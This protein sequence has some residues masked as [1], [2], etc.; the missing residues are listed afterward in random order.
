MKVRRNVAH[1]GVFGYEGGRR[2]EIVGKAL[3]GGA[4]A[5]AGCG[6]GGRADTRGWFLIDRGID[7]VRSIVSEQVFATQPVE[8]DIADAVAGAKHGL[9][10]DLVGQAQ[11][12]G[13]VM[14][15]RM[16]E[17]AMVEVAAAG[18][19]QDLHCGIEVI[20]QSAISIRS[21]AMRCRRC[22]TGFS[23]YSQFD[24]PIFSTRMTRNLV[25]EYDICNWRPP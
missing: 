13:P 5:S 1:L 3:V 8:L 14:A 23:R 9:R 7:D 10:G 16:H 17:R 24:T 4:E 22:A 2:S 15:V 18:E 20:R 6:G 11:A 21:M 19:D 25:F 12:R